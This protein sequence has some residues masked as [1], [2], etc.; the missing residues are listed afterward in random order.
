MNCATILALGVEDFKFSTSSANGTPQ[1][2]TV[3][4]ISKFRNDTTGAPLP[5]P[6]S[7]SSIYQ[8]IHQPAY[9]YLFP[10]N[11]VYYNDEEQ[12]QQQQQQ[13]NGSGLSSTLSG[14]GS[15]I[16]H[17]LPTIKN[18]ILTSSELPSS[19]T[20]VPVSSINFRVSVPVWKGN[21]NDPLTIATAYDVLN[22]N[23][24][25]LFT[26]LQQCTNELSLN[27]NMQNVIQNLLQT[28]EPED[29]D[30][31]R[32]A[33]R[34]LSYHTPLFHHFIA[35]EV[36]HK[37][38]NLW[39]IAYDSFMI[40]ILPKGKECLQTLQITLEKFNK[41]LELL[42]AG[43][44]IP[45]HHHHHRHHHRHPTH[46]VVS[47]SSTTITI[48]NTPLE[49]MFQELEIAMQNMQRAIV[50]FGEVAENAVASLHSCTG[51][52]SLLTDTL[53]ARL[54]TSSKTPKYHGGTNDTQ[55]LQSSSSSSTE[56]SFIQPTVNTT[57]NNS[58]LLEPS[59]QMDNSVILDVIGIASSEQEKES[60]DDDDEDNASSS[61]PSSSSSPSSTASHSTDQDHST[62]SGISVSSYQS[63]LEIARPT[64][65]YA[66]QTLFRITMILN[67]VQTTGPELLEVSTE[68]QN[69]FND[70]QN[71]IPLLRNVS[72]SDSVSSS[73]RID[74]ILHLGIV[75]ARFRT[76]C[77]D[78]D[79]WLGNLSPLLTL[80]HPLIDGTIHHSRK[81]LGVTNFTSQQK[82]LSNLHTV[83]NDHPSS[84]ALPGPFIGSESFGLRPIPENSSAETSNANS[85][86]A[87]RKNSINSVGTDI[88]IGIID[89]HD[90]LTKRLVS[91][92]L[93]EQGIKQ[94][95]DRLR[96]QYTQ[97]LDHLVTAAK[98]VQ[99]ELQSQ[100]EELMK[101]DTEPSNSDNIPKQAFINSPASPSVCIAQIISRIVTEV[102]HI[103]PNDHRPYQS[104][105]RTDRSASRTMEDTPDDT[106]S[107]E[108]SEVEESEEDELETNEDSITHHLS[109]HTDHGDARSKL[110]T[111]LGRLL[112]K[113]DQLLS[114]IETTKIDNI[115]KSSDTLLPAASFICPC[116]SCFI[117]RNQIMVQLQPELVQG[118]IPKDD[119][120]PFTSL[121]PF[122]SIIPNMSSEFQ[123]ICWELA[124]LGATLDLQRQL[125]LSPVI[126]DTLAT[127]QMQDKEILP[128]PTVQ[129]I[130][131][132]LLVSGINITDIA[133]CAEEERENAPWVGS[134]MEKMDSNATTKE[135]TNEKPPTT[136]STGA[137][138]VPKPSVISLNRKMPNSPSSLSTTTN[139]PT[140]LKRAVSRNILTQAASPSTV[141]L[142]QSLSSDWETISA[143]QSVRSVN[144]SVIT[145]NVPSIFSGD[146]ATNKP[147]PTP[148][149]AGPKT[150]PTEAVCQRQ[151]REFAASLSPNLTVRDI[152]AAFGAEVIQ[153]LVSMDPLANAPLMEATQCVIDAQRIKKALENKIK[154][155]KEG[156]DRSASTK[157]LQVKKLPTTE[158][159]GI[160]SQ[161][162]H[163]VQDKKA[164]L[165]RLS[166]LAMRCT[167][168]VSVLQASQLL[169]NKF[170]GATDGTNTTTTTYGGSM[171]FSSCIAFI[172]PSLGVIA[173]Y[174]GTLIITT[175]VSNS[176]ARLLLEECTTLLQVSPA[177]YLVRREDYSVQVNESITSTIEPGDRILYVQ[178]D[179]SINEKNRLQRLPLVNLPTIDPH[180]PYHHEYIRSSTAGIMQKLAR[181]SHQQ[182]AFVPQEQIITKNNG[183]ND[184]S[185]SSSNRLL[186]RSPPSTAK[187]SHR[188]KRKGKDTTDEAPVVILPVDPLGL[189][190]AFSSIG[191][192]TTGANDVLRVSTN[193]LL[194]QQRSTVVNHV[195]YDKS[196]S[197]RL[198]GI[199][200][201]P[202]VPP[203]PSP[204]FVNWNNVTPKK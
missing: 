7:S 123:V 28:I 2:I 29:P 1:I 130:T 78:F 184:S 27:Q 100:T 122:I 201:P 178:S 155:D 39:K 22:H 86:S 146:T 73:S 77:T 13:N 26:K 195:F 34:S 110:Y 97:L 134:E 188:K 15:G 135:K 45:M 44:S 83:T 139:L 62:V 11:K 166:R 153:S 9:A 50:Q 147:L 185:V 10:E 81:V 90:E 49:I 179:R 8:G 191:N 170:P 5:S 64:F 89:M 69:M 121:V 202:K 109:I 43:H 36:L 82:K 37:T 95:S 58:I 129:L 16:V 199:V 136:I 46:T 33:A 133:H 19:A 79:S 180:N 125:L 177:D 30:L 183:N 111:L 32:S 41:V 56:V 115:R 88:P 12:V 172:N 101:Q 118:A 71:R 59:S 158:R 25:K 116:Q 106:E 182:S 3:S 131:A 68:L 141:K 107:N 60:T 108:S 53:R 98:K 65:L 80:L 75:C 99:T 190:H 70:I 104:E 18:G 164:L 173:E 167:T 31:V 76:A 117:Q 161:A 193:A 189:R 186:Y 20:H 128:L 175:I 160:E 204:S 14:T 150:E 54:I 105:D 154:L 156:I 24:H 63:K 162:R 203:P 187:K 196:D 194:R 132:G 151:A 102:D 52:V 17:S 140:G 148:V 42:H 91:L 145:N 176:L 51:G 84:S 48:V 112:R 103:V 157:I 138:N 40:A 38:S 55:I 120:V 137:E 66:I 200:L 4:S 6:S 124:E 149:L 192:G 93:E 127:I 87:S 142:S 21:R 47:S 168:P 126:L 96:I 143:R 171:Y 72:L 144:S 159:E 114:S 85:A 197:R 61:L 119:P 94:R 181:L 198:P 67:C 23:T 163:A 174:L 92:T 57:T 165:N 35:D 74:D 152:L 169:E 113:N